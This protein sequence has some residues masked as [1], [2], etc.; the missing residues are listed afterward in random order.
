MCVSTFLP[1]HSQWLYCIQGSLKVVRPLNMSARASLIDF[2]PHGAFRHSNPPGADPLQSNL[3]LDVLGGSYNS[4]WWEA[5]LQWAWHLTRSCH[6]LKHQHVVITASLHHFDNTR[7]TQA[8]ETLKKKKDVSLI[9]IRFLLSVEGAGCTCS[10]KQTIPHQAHKWASSE[11]QPGRHVSLENISPLKRS[12][13]QLHALLLSGW[14]GWL[15]L[16]PYP[17][18]SGEQRVEN[19]K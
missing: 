8:E 3:L 5:G 6:R 9:C 10:L 16:P 15:V 11:L 12:D 17:E 7:E 13:N 19:N 4:Q 18:V 2:S 1:L 14:W